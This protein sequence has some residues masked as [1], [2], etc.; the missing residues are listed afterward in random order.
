MHEFLDFYGQHLLHVTH[1]SNISSIVEQ[2]GIHSRDFLNKNN[3]PIHTAGNETSMLWDDQQNLSSFVYLAASEFHKMIY[4]AIGNK[5]DDYVL[6]YIHRDILLAPGVRYYKQ[7]ANVSNGNYFNSVD[8]FDLEPI[9]HDIDVSTIEGLARSKQ[10]CNM[11]ILVPD[12]IPLWLTSLGGNLDWG[13]SLPP[14][15]YIGC[16]YQDAMHL[17]YKDRYPGI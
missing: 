14:E 4:R 13:P 9:A 10:A 16:G 1:K 2:E 11:E 5:T 7:S 12:F 15:G 8:S 3:I 6:I 17:Y